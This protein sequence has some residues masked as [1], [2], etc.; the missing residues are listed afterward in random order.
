MFMK[1]FDCGD[2][3]LLKEYVGNVIVYMADGGLKF[4]QPVLTQSYIDEFD[5]N[6]GKE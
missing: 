4:T 1:Q 5:I 3:G 6:T 2:V